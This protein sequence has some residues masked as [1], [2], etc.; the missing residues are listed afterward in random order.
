MTVDK[1]FESL[2]YR[3]V[4]Y[5]SPHTNEVPFFEWWWDKDKER[6]RIRFVPDSETVYVV[7]TYNAHHIPTELSLE[8]ITAIHMQCTELGWKV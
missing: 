2:G 1:I 7:S 8:E 3:K 6:K 4:D 5:N